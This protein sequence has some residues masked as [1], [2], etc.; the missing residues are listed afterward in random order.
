MIHQKFL[1]IH[2][3]WSKTKCLI[4]Y[5]YEHSWQDAI[6]QF[7]IWIQPHSSGKFRNKH[8]RPPRPPQK[9]KS[10]DMDS[11]WWNH[12]MSLFCFVDRGG[13]F[14]GRKRDSNVG[15]LANPRWPQ[16]FRTKNKIFRWGPPNTWTNIDM[17]ATKPR[18]GQP[19]WW[20]LQRNLPKNCS[21][22]PRYIPWRIHGTYIYLPNMKTHK[23]Q[24]FM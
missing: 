7:L 4:L 20:W 14:R 1:M 23:N 8:F 11:L 18:V 10:S 21:N 3:K 19:K 24:P 9:T 22:S 5:D 12:G 13:R 16:V 6:L 2:Q 17:I 15:F